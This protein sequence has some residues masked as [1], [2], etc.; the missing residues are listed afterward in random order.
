MKYSVQ[1]LA[2]EDRSNRT[3]KKLRLAQQQRVRPNFSKETRTEAFSDLGWRLSAARTQREAAQI[4][5]ETA[6][7]VFGWDA[8]TFDLYSSENG[9]VSTVLYMDTIE[10]KRVDVSRKCAGTQPSAHTLHAI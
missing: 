1:S 8:C 3:R 6:A 2:R 4:L 9:T 7:E 5:M 10:G